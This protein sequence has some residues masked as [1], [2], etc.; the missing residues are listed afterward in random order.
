MTNLE[1]AELHKA[2]LRASRYCAEQDRAEFDVRRKLKDWDVPA[3]LH[4]EVISMLK[5]ENFIDEWRFA[6]TFVRSKFRNNRWGKIKIAYALRQK[7]ISEDI[8]SESL[9]EIKDEDYLN[10]LKELATKKAR[11][12]NAETDYKKKQKIAQSLAKKAMNQNCFIR[13]FLKLKVEWQS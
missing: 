12:V 13:W 4:D 1:K 5:E 6:C 10:A 11:T 7:Q 3:H 2:M 8:I 9:K